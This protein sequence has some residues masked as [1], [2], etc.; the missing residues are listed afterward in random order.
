MK[1]IACLA[2]FPEVFREAADPLQILFIRVQMAS[3]TDVKPPLFKVTVPRG[4][5][6][7]PISFENPC[8]LLYGTLGNFCWVQSRC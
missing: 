8:D 5:Q 2:G 6:K 1:A 4:S 7:Q 3:S